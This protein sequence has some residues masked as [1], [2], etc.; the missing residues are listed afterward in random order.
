MMPKEAKQTRTLHVNFYA[1]GNGSC[2][3]TREAADKFAKHLADENPRIACRPVAALI[4]DGLG[5]KD[6][7]GRDERLAHE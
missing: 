4:G 3:F 2:H 1:R 6:G 5:R 7:C